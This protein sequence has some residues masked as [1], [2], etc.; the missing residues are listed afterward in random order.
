MSLHVV[1]WII[2]NFDVTDTAGGYWKF[3]E[4]RMTPRVNR[5]ARD[6]AVEQSLDAAIEID[7]VIRGIR[8]ESPAFGKLISILIG[9]PANELNAVKK[10]L[11]N[12][13][14]LASLYYRAA[15]SS[16]KATSSVEDVDYVLGLLLSAGSTVLSKISKEDLSFVRDFCIRLRGQTS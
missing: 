7:E 6:L 15:K 16:G 11:L 12:D 4:Q 5:V 3:G 1:K 9:S 14:R 8:E 10:Q 13:S 2:H